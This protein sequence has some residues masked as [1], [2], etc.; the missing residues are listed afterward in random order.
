MVVVD[1]TLDDSES[2]FIIDEALDLGFNYYLTYDDL[3]SPCFSY[4]NL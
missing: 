1:L 3:V 2:F 4:S